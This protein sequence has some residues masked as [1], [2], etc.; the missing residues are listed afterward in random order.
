MA[1]EKRRRRDVPFIDFTKRNG[2]ESSGT[3]FQDTRRLPENHS[4]WRVIELYIGE[5]KSRRPDP[6]SH[7]LVRPEQLFKI[8]L[9]AVVTEGKHRRHDEFALDMENPYLAAMPRKF[10]FR[11]VADFSWTGCLAT[12]SA[13]PETQSISPPH[14]RLRS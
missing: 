5:R 2:K 11:F 4:I 8:P 7:I 6:V 12:Q 14:P 1:P 13:V 10:G 9:I 3:S